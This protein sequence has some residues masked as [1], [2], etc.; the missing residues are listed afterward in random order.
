MKIL[1]T[2]SA[3]RELVD[4]QQRQKMLLE[5]LISDRKHVFGDDVLEITASDIKEA[6]HRIQPIR[7]AVRSYQSSEL[8]TKAYVVM[9]IAMMVGAFF[10]REI[11]YIFETNRTQ[12]LIF[13][14]GAF[15]TAIGSL[16]GYWVK[17]RRRRYA[18]QLSKL[19]FLE[20]AQF[21]T[22]QERASEKPSNEI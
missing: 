20:S 5:E 4:F 8:L 15:I 11:L 2:N 21:Q 13:S 22:T 14:T 10:Y 3:Q 12:A 16:F 1:Y 18:E 19:E 17:L 6:A 7:P 9:G